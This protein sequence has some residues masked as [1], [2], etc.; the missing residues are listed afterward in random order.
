MRF[1]L[2]SNCEAQ[3]HNATLLNYCISAADLSAFSS[4]HQLLLLRIA[5]LVNHLSPIT[6][7]TTWLRPE[8]IWMYRALLGNLK[9]LDPCL[10]DLMCEM[11]AST[12][13]ITYYFAFLSM[14][15][16]SN[17]AASITQNVFKRTRWS[18]E[19]KRE[20]RKELQATTPA[21]NRKDIVGGAAET[22]L[23]R[24]KQQGMQF[25]WMRIWPSIATS[26]TEACPG[27]AHLPAGAKHSRRTRTLG[28]PLTRRSSCETELDW[29][30]SHHAQKKPA[31][32]PPHSKSH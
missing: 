10:L 15:H 23:L 19:S 24:F 28:P 29:G 25:V 22:W 30:G 18:T 20:F 12:R 2:R 8:N 26:S 14:F 3:A 16:T 4:N 1:S 31:P 17:C 32:C 11:P 7:S 6:T 9:N 5:V 21:G 27:N 13:S